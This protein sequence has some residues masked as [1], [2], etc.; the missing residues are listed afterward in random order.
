MISFAREV[1]Q[2]IAGHFMERSLLPITKGSLLE[3]RLKNLQINYVDAQNTYQ[4]LIDTLAALA[5][6]IPMPR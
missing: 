2:T 3:E 1:V 5:W 4:A 6:S